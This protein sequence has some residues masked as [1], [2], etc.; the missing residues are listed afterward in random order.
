MIN[1]YFKLCI[2]KIN[3]LDKSYF[4]EI[5]FSS[6]DKY[7]IFEKVTSENETIAT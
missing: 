6:P 3:S 2:K 1:L 7:K 5:L 4:T